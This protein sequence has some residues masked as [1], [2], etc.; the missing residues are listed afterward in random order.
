M[1][2]F[3]VIIEE[4]GELLGTG[5]L[6]LGVLGLIYGVVSFFWA[7]TASDDSRKAQ[8]FAAI[9]GGVVLILLGISIHTNFATWV[10]SVI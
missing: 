9:A 7:K 10:L 8:S 4:M 5:I 6:I 3:S 2:P 1:G